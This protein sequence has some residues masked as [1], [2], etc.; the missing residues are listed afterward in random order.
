[1]SSLPFCFRTVT[2]STG[3]RGPLIKC[4]L[5]A[6][7]AGS[8]IFGM[9]GCSAEAKL[10]RRLSKANAFFDTGE[11]EKAEIE[12][13]NAL[14]LVPMNPESIS[15]LGLIFAAQGRS[16]VTAGFLIKAKEL[17][18]E[19]LDVRIKLGMLYASTGRLS[20]ARDEAQFVLERRPKDEDAPMLLAE[21]VSQPK[22]IDEMRVR[23]RKLPDA[24]T[25]PFLLALGLLDIRQ[26]KFKEAEGLFQ[27]ARVLAP[28]SGPV[29]FSLGRLHVAQKNM[30]EAAI[31][32]ANAASLS[33]MRSPLRIHYAQFSLQTGKTDVAKQ[34]LTEVTQKTPDYIPAWMLLATIAATEKKPVD[35]LAAV[36][37]ALALDPLNHD[38]VLMRARLMFDKGD[39]D[40]AVSELERQAKIF[41]KSPEMQFQLA[42][43]H[44]AM[45]SPEKAAVSLT[46]GLTLA[47]GIPGPVMML[48]EINIRLGKI[49]LA[50]KAL[51]DLIQKTPALAEARMLLAQAYRSQGN[52]DEA[53]VVYRQ[54]DASFSPNPQPSYMSGLVYLQQ[55]KFDEAR[56]AFAK[57]VEIDPT[58]LAA[59]EQLINSDLSEKKFVEAKQKVD[60]LIAKNPK[61]AELQVLLARVQLAAADN[62]SGEAAL[63]QVV[64]LQPDS[65]AGYLMLARFYIS[66]KQKEKALTNLQQALAKNPK[67]IEALMLLAAIK[68]EQND[69][70]GAREYYEK[71]IALNPKLAAAQNNLAVIYSERFNDLEKGLQAAQLAREL[72]PRDPNI[73]DTLGWIVFKKK[74]Y[75]R[76][77]TLLSESAEKLPESAD[78]QFHLGMAHY[79]MG[80]EKPA[81]AA[82]ERAISLSPTF[83]GIGE[84]KRALAVL[85]I[86]PKT[87]GST[88]IA[89][90][91]KTM[92]ERPDDLV[93]VARLSALYQ[94]TGAIDKANGLFEAA[95]KANPSNPSAVLNM[96][97]VHVFRKETA[98]ALELAKGVRKLAPDDPDIGHS[99]GRIA[100]AAGDE[101]WALS[102][103]QESARK[104]PDNSAVLF[105]LAEVSY[106]KGQ[107]AAADASMKE[108]LK[109]D[110]NFPQASK[111]KN[112]IEMIELASN[113]ALATA[114]LGKV[115]QKLKSDPTDVPSLMVVATAQEG[116]KDFTEAQK[117][118]EKILARFPSFSAA[119]ARLTIIYSRT[120]GNDAKA[121]ERGVLAREA[122]PADM[123]LAKALG[124]ILYRQANYARAK[125]LLQES[126]RELSD[127]AELFYYL[128]MSQHY[129]KDWAASSRSLQRA[130]ELGLKS[131]LASEA[132]R[133]LASPAKK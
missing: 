92:A 54:I 24:G 81:Q 43:N 82:L 42:R 61:A 93:A 51:K 45:G 133:V 70:S 20:D 110:P 14:Q 2:A 39:K 111:A 18:P 117:T 76:A 58:F 65:P 53:L 26:G 16:G 106:A 129:M 98:K 74:Q 116:R 127:D 37:K 84:A 71:A 34:T 9:A 107:V 21:T 118:Y 50:T 96:V 38:A 66:S 103:L 46:Q 101:S 77:L 31:A 115:E 63:L 128:G 119:M 68:E 88:A 32:F 7:L 114:S 95:Y 99:L 5:A 78:V 83:I 48:A 33:P 30:A 85:G 6:A 55:K 25:A 131:D 28:K 3:L 108:A 40:A 121:I 113:P 13:K 109:A 59:V 73:A 10:A 22:D 49:E 19:N 11:Y 29:S 89:S 47:P 41:P 67:N 60:A 17:Q 72:V 35:G 124:L 120:S 122:L 12:Y 130:Q 4:F 57:A 62:S 64:A 56:K 23:L 27:Q 112:L 104:L 69:Y 123:E 125:S 126:S 94:Q 80:A 1:M 102:L 91:E 100:F 86:D 79:M 15:R 90:L 8:M 52:L 36:A 87:G 44:L 75:G 97:R 132:K 105:D